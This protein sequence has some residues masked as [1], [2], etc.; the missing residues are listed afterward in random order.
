MKSIK[1]MFIVTLLIGCNLFVYSQ[2]QSTSGAETHQSTTQS[3]DLMP[4]RSDFNTWSL[5]VNFGPSLFYGTVTSQ[6]Y[7]IQRP[8][9]DMG[10]YYGLTLKK[11]ITHLFGIEG[12]FDLGQL[13]GKNSTFEATMVTTVHYDWSV[14][15]VFTLGNFTWLSRNHKINLRGSFGTGEVNFTPTLSDDVVQPKADP[16]NITPPGII[17]PG[18]QHSWVGLGNTT[19]Y[20]FPLSIGALYDLDKHFNLMAR[21]RYTVALGSKLDY[22]WNPLVYH[23]SYGWFSIGVIYIFGKKEKNI[24]WV[25]PIGEIYNEL[26]N[27]D[28]K[29]DGLADTTKKQLA[30]MQ[31]TV[32]S[33]AKDV[34]KKLKDNDAK[35]DDFNKNLQNNVNSAINNYVTNNS[36]LSGEMY[37]PS[38]YFP[39]DVYSIQYTDYESLAYIAKVMKAHKEMKLMISGNCDERNTV[40][41]NKRLGQNRADE[42]KK[43]LVKVYG[44]DGSRLSTESKGKS[45]PLA[46]DLLQINRR[47]DFSI[48]GG[49]EKK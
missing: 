25:N 12:E 13:K 3:F 1:L 30:A 38:I 49:K 29:I 24:D 20:I 48:M 18:V 16:F 14:N 21:Y 44:I 39:T 19:E 26:A 33:L 31:N 6:A 8:V 27:V 43:H 10:L 2:S 5:G 36:S 40:E 42:A 4:K 7:Y 22:T 47:V 11:S 17:T 28:R 35:M 45:E 34:D 9:N 41:Y 37:L 46:K 32:D 23:Q 15:A